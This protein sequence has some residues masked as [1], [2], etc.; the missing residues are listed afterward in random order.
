MA[1]T[2]DRAAGLSVTYGTTLHALKDRAKLKAGRDAGG[3]GRRRRHRSGRGRARQADGRARHRLRIVGRKAC[4][5]AQA[6]R[7]RWRRTT[8]ANDLKEALRQLTGGTGVDVVYDPIG[9]ALGRSRVARHGLGAGAFWSSALPPAKCRS[10]RSTW[11][12][13]EG[14][15][16]LGVFW[17]CM[18]RARSGRPPRQHGANAGLVRGREIVVAR[19]RGLSAGRSAGRAQGDRRAAGDGQ[20]DIEAVIA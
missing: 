20:G 14:Y 8:A 18:D 19:A 7:R 12:C 10:C 4:L 6:R 17:G 5:R 9:G 15:D 11:C 2:F 13:C 3:A 16:V 1:S